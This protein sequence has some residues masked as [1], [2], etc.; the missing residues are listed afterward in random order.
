M[1]SLWYEGFGLIVMEAM[2]RGIPVVSSDSGGLKEAKHGTGYVIPVRTIERYQEVYDEHAMP[3]PVVPEN[4]AA[5]WIAAIS[6]LLSDRA[7]YERESAA[8][9]SAAAAFVASL[10]AGALGC[11]LE[12]LSAAPPAS[13]PATMESLS[14][15]KRAL[16]LQR[17][18]P[19]Q[20]SPLMRIL[21]AQNSLYFPAHGGGD[22]SN[23]LLIEALAA[24]G[25]AC[26]VVARTSAF[27]EAEH[28]AYLAQLAQRGVQPDAASGGVV[29]F[30][31]NGV[32]VRVVTNTGLRPYFADQIESFRPDA[33]LASTDDPAQL[34][35]ETAL[36]S[37]ARVVYS[38]ASHS[39]GSVRPRLRLGQRSQN[40]ADPR[41]RPRRRRQRVCCPLRPPAHRDRRRSRP[42]LFNG[43]S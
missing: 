8:S 30:D 36:R 41:S 13:A 15:Q 14:P 11:Y 5:S 27:G 7:A 32:N 20:G 28:H 24:R 38:G 35:L 10:D 29:A 39:G 2:L 16:L 23:R 12:S 21:L 4:D 43:A 17:L 34:L 1:P 18:P 3:R 9:R 6:E 25:H 26:R 40:R 37:Q 33:I 22:K 42:H 31:R 19:A